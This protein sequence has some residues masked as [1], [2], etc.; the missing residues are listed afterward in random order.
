MTDQSPANGALAQAVKAADTARKGITLP[1]VAVG[2]SGGAILTALSFQAFLD[3]MAADLGIGGVVMFIL[4]IGAVCFIVFLFR[5]IFIQWR[6]GSLTGQAQAAATTQ[7]AIAEAATTLELKG[8]RASVEGMAQ[9]IASLDEDMRNS[10]TS[11]GA[12]REAVADLRAEVVGMVRKID[13]LPLVER[14]HGSH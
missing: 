5:F 12:L 4:L 11:T 7:S 10:T 1:G 3:R 8:L 6:E 9:R 2:A 13:S 14:R